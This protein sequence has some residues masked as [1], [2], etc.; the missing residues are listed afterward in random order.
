MVNLLCITA[1]VPPP[2]NETVPVNPYNRIPFSEKKGKIRYIVVIL[3]FQRSQFTNTII[4]NGDFTVRRLLT[5]LRWTSRSSLRRSPSSWYWKMRSPFL[6]KLEVQTLENCRWSVITLVVVNG[7]FKRKRKLR[8]YSKRP[9]KTKQR[10]LLLA[11]SPITQFPSITVSLSI[12]L[13]SENSN[14]SGKVPK[15]NKLTKTLKSEKWK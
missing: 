14:F 6:W 5:S 2:L 15:I 4:L 8:L 12:K 10:Y 3:S 11:D 13:K 7:K 1:A 9:M